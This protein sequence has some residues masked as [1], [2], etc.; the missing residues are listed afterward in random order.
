[1]KALDTGQIRN[2]TLAGHT[3]T[4]KTS[5]AE[6]MIWS[7]KQAGHLGKI[8]D[9]NTISDYDS[10]EIRRH[11]SIQT[12]VVAFEYE[13]IRVNV[14]DTPGY[15]DFIG[16]IKQ[17]IRASEGVVL[18]ADATGGLDTGSE[19]AFE[20]ACE[21][22]QPMLLFINKMDK[23][24]ASFE[25]SVREISKGLEI[26]TVP[27]ALPAGEASEFKGVIDLV[28]MKYVEEDG[29]KVSY[30]NI[31][32]EYS[33]AAD[34]ARAELVEIAAE[35]DEALLEK[36]LEEE[37]LT[38]D[39]ILQGLKKGLCEKLFVPVLCGSATAVKGIRP[40]LEFVH[41]CVSDPSNSASYQF[42]AEEDAE[43]ETIGI[44][45]EGDVL[46]YVFKTAVDPYAGKRSLFKVLRGT[47]VPATALTNLSRNCE[48]KAGHLL[49]CSGSK[50][51]EI[52]KITA[53]DIGVLAKLDQV[54]TG[55]TL[56][57]SGTTWPPLVSQP[58]LPKPTAF[59]AVHARSRADEDKVGMGFHRLTEQDTTLEVNRDASISQTIM[60]GMGDLH[61]QVAVARLKELAKV[62]IDPEIPRV[63]YRETITRSAEGQGKHKKQSGGHGQYGD[64]WVRFEPLPEGSGFEFVWEIVGGA[65][66]TNYK[67]AVE[68]G[69]SESLERGVL[70][71]HQTVDVKA[72]CYDGTYHA[73]DS[74]DMAFKVAAS[75]AFKNIIPNCGPIMLEPIYKATIT[76]PEDY[77]GDIMGDLNGRRGRILGMNPVG[78]KQVVEAHVPLSELYTYGRQLNSLSQGRGMWEME[79]DHYARVPADV[80]EKI[81][82]SCKQE[83]EAEMEAH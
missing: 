61:L 41:R 45:P 29:Q 63:P 50:A 44:T 51:V 32:A 31:P 21:Y 80:Q 11:A 28:R 37:S 20:V 79:F 9:G 42:E 38:S 54:K 13:D 58:R 72:T 18:I 46:I 22:N 48:E 25:K 16:E 1:L 34:T 77:T 40:L 82:Q 19:H 17:G 24:S 39:E 57:T 14:L 81:I 71:G 59:M 10:E 12:S 70:S 53:G 83:K 78:R 33:D 67:S 47:L 52:D 66:P 30:S 62:D 23:E 8:E 35:G 2:I 55:D 26:R 76:V 73:V 5:L 68:K 3:Q 15:W 49:V 69:L 74:S 75:V 60:S 7:L 6:A 65:I 64:C 43:P 36:F 4:G 56:V 27:L